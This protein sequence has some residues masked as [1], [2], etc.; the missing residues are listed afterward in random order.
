LVIIDKNRYKQQI[1]EEIMNTKSG[2]FILF[3]VLL[4][5]ATS[6]FLLMFGIFSIRSFR[7]GEIL[8]L[9]I[10]TVFVF[11]VCA[12]VGV[13]VYRDAK[14]LGMDPWLWVCV[15][16]FLP[17][18]IGVIIYLLVRRSQ[19]RKCVK[20][21]QPLQADFKMCPYCGYDHEISCDNCKKTAAPDW[22]VCPYCGDTLRKND[23]EVKD[24]V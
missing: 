9:G 3:W 4:V 20:C 21:L 8:P 17:N 7:L 5:L 10:A 6:G 16:V 18:L 11:I 13:L 24:D 2:F 12:V 22:T 19:R 23:V 14:N 15:A 1:K